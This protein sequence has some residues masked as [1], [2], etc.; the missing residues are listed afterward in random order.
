MKLVTAPNS[1]QGAPMKSPKLQTARMQNVKPFKKLS[2]QIVKKLTRATQA[3]QKSPSETI[4][5]P[6]LKTN[7]GDTEASATISTTSQKPQGLPFIKDSKGSR[8]AFNLLLVRPWVL[9]VGLW[10]LSAVSASIA[11]QGMISP[12]QLT[13]D[14][15]QSNTETKSTAEKNAFLSVE[16][17]AEESGG[18]KISE[19]APA[20]TTSAN[21]QVSTTNTADTSGFPTWPIGLL[22]GSCAAGCLAISRRRAMVRMASVRSRGKRRVRANGEVR[23]S[24]PIKKV[25]IRTTA[26]SAP[27][28]INRPTGRV[29]KGKQ[30]K[31]KSPS[32]QPVMAKAAATQSSA[33]RGPLKSGKRRLRKRVGA[34][35]AK[36]A[37][38]GNRVLASRSTAKQV[39]PDTH[40]SR[41]AA[42]PAVKRNSARRGANRRQP[43]VS[44]VPASASHAL[45]WSNGSLAHQL[46]VRPERTAM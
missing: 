15:P 21:S 28:P 14:L 9:V 16:Q 2:R 37:A 23:I 12:R 31:G 26:K 5:T 38:V 36:P 45:D 4:Q 10:L 11:W 44:V 19:A 43:V 18:L 24:E 17:D 40:S 29:L 25:A 1:S 8:L 30:K 42:R 6:V 41:K 7:Q 13:M 35:Q 32:R 27:R 22:V 3:K 20:Q 34:P 39:V 33:A 46:D